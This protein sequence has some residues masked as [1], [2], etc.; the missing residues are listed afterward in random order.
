MRELALK[1]FDYK[2]DSKLSDEMVYDIVRY[3]S[4]IG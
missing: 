2:E 3:V 4:N 1:H